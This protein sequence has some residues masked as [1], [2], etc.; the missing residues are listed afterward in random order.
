MEKKKIG[1]MQNLFEDAMID[2]IMK[3]ELEKRILS[4]LNEM[5]LKIIKV[6][7]GFEGEA[8]D[9][10]ATSS[11]FH[12]SKSYTQYIEYI[13]LKKIKYI[14]LKYQNIII[15]SKIGIDLVCLDEIT[16]FL[17]EQLY[18]YIK[19]NALGV[20]ATNKKV[21]LQRWLKDFVRFRL[22]GK[23][24]EFLLQKVKRSYVSIPLRERLYA[25]E[26][27]Y[28]ILEKII[29][30]LRNNIEDCKKLSVHIRK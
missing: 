27:L 10:T 29:R 23:E 6:R 5:E 20:F 24:K 13:A 2:K 14:L 16:Q 30:E 26:Q 22:D 19:A 8:L 3:E 7:Y 18:T 15:D 12:L 28:S 4:E 25:Q 1:Y 17:S 21:A 11:L 9:A